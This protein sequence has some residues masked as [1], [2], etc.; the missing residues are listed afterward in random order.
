M[1]ERQDNDQTIIR[2]ELDEK[3]YFTRTREKKEKKK[4]KWKHKYVHQH[5]I[6]V[7]SNRP[8]ARCVANLA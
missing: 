4:K 1:F 2:R 7:F 3:E 8:V 5:V 6:Y